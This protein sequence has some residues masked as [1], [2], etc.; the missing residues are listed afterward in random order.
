MITPMS[1]VKSKKFKDDFMDEQ[2]NYKNS[3]S[4]KKLP[5]QNIQQ[6]HHDEEG[7]REDPL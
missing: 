3:T 1:Q 7:K 6:T 5:D 4:S 2:D